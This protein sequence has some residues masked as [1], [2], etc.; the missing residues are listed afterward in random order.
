[1]P[2]YSTRINGSCRAKT[3]QISDAIRADL[4][5]RGIKAVI[6]S[7]SNRKVTIGYN[8]RLYRKRKCIERVIGHFK[9]NCAIAT[10][11]NHLVGSFLR[12]LY[13]IARYWIKF[14][15]AA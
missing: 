4:K 2:I 12:M 3:S 1:M 13:L 8:K 5:E 9:I 11:Y 14:V 10:R 7:K 6:P 15:H